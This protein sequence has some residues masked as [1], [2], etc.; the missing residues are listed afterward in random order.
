ML[1]PYLEPYLIRTMKE[2]KKHVTDPQLVSDMERFSAQEGQYFKEQMRFN[3][4]IRKSFPGLTTLE[5]ELEADYQRFFTT[6]CTG[7]TCIGCA[8]EVLR[9]G[10]SCVLSGA[11]APT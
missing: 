9:S 6:T 7:A 10:T 8:W 2:A 5:A 11:S 4:V 1:L 3:E